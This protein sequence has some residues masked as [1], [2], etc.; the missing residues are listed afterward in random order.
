MAEFFVWT[1]RRAHECQRD[2]GRR[3]AARAAGD[4]TLLVILGVVLIV[5]LV[6]ENARHGPVKETRTGSQAGDGGQGGDGGG[7]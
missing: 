3:T 1:L 2:A 4:M 5:G 7:G 6:I